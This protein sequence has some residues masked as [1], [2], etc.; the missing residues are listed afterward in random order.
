MAKT[1]VN[2]YDALTAIFKGGR[3]FTMDQLVEMVAKKTG[4]SVT[5]G[6]ISVQLS[7]LRADGLKIETLRGSESKAKDGSTQYRVS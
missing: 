2:Q 6:S 5:P 7:H 3:R 1:K 4:R